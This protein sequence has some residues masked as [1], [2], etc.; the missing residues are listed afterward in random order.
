MSHPDVW[1][2]SA[3]VTWKETSSGYEKIEAIAS[4]TPLG[5]SVLGAEPRKLKSN[6][7]NADVIEAYG[8]YPQNAP[9][10]FD[11]VSVDQVFYI[12]Q[13]LS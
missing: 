2:R 1:L 6:S 12:F 9:E 7:T 4:P 11:F 5:S 3:P 13:I 10:T 8:F